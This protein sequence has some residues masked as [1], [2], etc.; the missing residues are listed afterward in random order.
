VFLFRQCYGLLAFRL[1]ILLW[2]VMVVSIITRKDQLMLMFCFFHSQ[3][4]NKYQDALCTSWK[5]MAG[6]SLLQFHALL[7]S[8]LSVT[9]R[10]TYLPIPPP[11]VSVECESSWTAGLVWNRCRNEKYSL[12]PAITSDM[13]WRKLTWPKIWAATKTG[14]IIGNERTQMAKKIG[15][16]IAAQGTTV[17]RT[18]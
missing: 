6:M 16:P 11:H 14:Y 17:H 18:T 2:T 1:Q 3:L 4:H 13:T 5:C 9:Y 7:H 10:P 15:C 12:P 8:V